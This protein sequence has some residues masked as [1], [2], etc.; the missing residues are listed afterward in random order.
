MESAH[1]RTDGSTNASRPS[2][3]AA[4]A[5]NTYYRV[6]DPDV[7]CAALLHDAVEDHAQDI[8]PGGTRQAAFVVLARQFGHR[9]SDLVAAVTNPVYEPGRDEHEQYLEHV[10]ASLQASPWAR[11][12]KHPISPTTPWA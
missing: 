2:S 5:R 12:I 7:A 9:T 10:S 3:T 1:S 11:V 8:A 6:A 4:C